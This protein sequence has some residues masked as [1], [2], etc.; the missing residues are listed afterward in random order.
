MPMLAALLWLVYPP[1]GG[2]I[3][4]PQ[5]AVRHTVALPQFGRSHCIVPDVDGDGIEDVL[6]AEPTE[7]ASAESERSKGAVY[8]LS[9]ATGEGLRRFVSPADVLQLGSSMAAVPPAFR[10]RFGDVVVLSQGPGTRE[11]I[12]IDFL[13]LSTGLRL[14]QRMLVPVVKRGSATRAL[15]LPSD[16]DGQADLLIRHARY[17]GG[18]VLL[19]VSLRSEGVVREV[20]VGGPGLASAE[21]LEILEPHGDDGALLLCGSPAIGTSDALGRVELI[22]L[23]DGEIVHTLTS[24]SLGPHFGGA[25]TLLPGEPGSS[26]LASTLPRHWGGFQA[27]HVDAVSLY[28]VT[29]P[30]HGGEWQF[31]P[32]ALRGLEGPDLQRVGGHVSAMLGIASM[33]PQD[34]SPILVLACPEEAF[35]AYIYGFDANDYTKLWRTSADFA[36]RSDYYFGSVLGTQAFDGEGAEAWFLCGTAHH[37]TGHTPWISAVRARDGKV[38]WHQNLETVKAALNR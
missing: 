19:F 8:L 21:T 28:E 29:V 30:V 3:S 4:E 18:A 36:E 37:L 5:Q 15:F 14:E 23:R 25:I 16:P 9:G 22:R 10:S 2:W 7:R 13:D 32:V 27:P 6:V 17:P 35:T 34:D 24:K 1:S 38:I 12:Q 31:H 33:R 20:V 26:F 11:T